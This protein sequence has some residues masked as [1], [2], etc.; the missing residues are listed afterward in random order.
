MQNGCPSCGRLLEGYFEKCPHCG[1]DLISLHKMVDKYEKEREKKQK[2]KENASKYA[3]F[4]QRVV[5]NWI[6]FWFVALA[7]LAIFIVVIV[8]FR[9]DFSY[10]FCLND[11]SRLFV[12]LLYYII[13]YFFYC[14]FCHYSKSGATIGEKIVGIRVVDEKCLPLGYI[15]VI[16]HNLFRIFNILTL[17]IGALFIIFTKDKQALSDIM[18]HTYVVNVYSDDDEYLYYASI[19]SRFFANLIDIAFI[20]LAAFLV[21][22]FFLLLFCLAIIV[23]WCLMESRWGGTIGKLIMNIKITDYNGD[24]IGFGR[25]LVRNLA[26]LLEL[27]V[28]IFGTI[29]CFTSPRKQTLKDMLTKTVV[30]QK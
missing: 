1:Y 24:N 16:T 23:C 6:D 2:R 9:L 12:M 4:I 14:V 13:L 20:L 15:E 21:G 5:A 19:L 3:G 11:Y 27:F 17:G 29:I 28:L 30:I 18:S 22:R 10:A 25:S 26:I 8:V 7:F